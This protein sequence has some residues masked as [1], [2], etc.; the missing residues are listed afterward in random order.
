MTNPHRVDGRYQYEEK[1]DVEKDG[2]TDK[3]AKEGTEDKQ[4]QYGDEQKEE[5]AY[6][7]LSEWEMIRLGHGCFFRFSCFEIEMKSL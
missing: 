3:A 5:S 1:K 2:N 4:E 7:D 6:F